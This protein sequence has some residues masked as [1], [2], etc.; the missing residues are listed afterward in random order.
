M[1]LFLDTSSLFMLYHEEEGSLAVERLFTD[2]KVTA[3]FLSELTKIEF[4]STVWKKVRTGAIDER[5]ASLSSESL[6]TE[7]PGV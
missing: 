6:P 3:V 7:L 2:H 1:R 5:Q 4:A